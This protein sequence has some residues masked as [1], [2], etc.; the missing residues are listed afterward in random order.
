MLPCRQDYQKLEILTILTY[1]AFVASSGGPEKVADFAFSERYS[2][3][4]RKISLAQ[5]FRRDFRTFLIHRHTEKRR[6]MGR[7]YLSDHP[8]FVESWV[9]RDR[10]LCQ[11]RRHCLLLLAKTA[12]SAL[13]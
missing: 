5:D 4:I 13:G 10:G 8:Q 9:S 2:E 11:V 1:R 7:T 12:K 6:P 3:I